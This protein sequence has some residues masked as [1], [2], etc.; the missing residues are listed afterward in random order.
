[1]YVNILAPLKIFVED[2]SLMIA[3]SEND[4]SDGSK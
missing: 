1:V 4:C 2:S 3:S